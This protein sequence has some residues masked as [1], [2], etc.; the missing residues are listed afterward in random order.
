[1]QDAAP[2]NTLMSP[3]EAADYLHIS[4]VMLA[5]MRWSGTSGLPYIKLGRRTIR[6]RR[7]DLD[8]WLTQ[9]EVCRS[10]GEQREAAVA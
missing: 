2:T 10:R 7:S 6:Y 3:D 9:R 5:K 8:R 4:T 1:M